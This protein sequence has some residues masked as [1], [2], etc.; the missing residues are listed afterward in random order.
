MSISR[1]AVRH[2]IVMVVPATRNPN[3]R[4]LVQYMILIYSDPAEMQQQ[5]E[6]E[7]RQMVGE[8][9]AYSESL[10]QAGVYQSGE[11][12]EPPSTATTVRVRDGKQLI[13][14]GPFAETREV[15]GGFY[16]IECESLDDALTHA[17]ACPGARHGSVEVR[18]VMQIPART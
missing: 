3:E 18:P 9:M 4:T 6:S 10:R 5:P 11:G 8:Y 15:L 1:F 14:D 7:Q 2:R 17:A 12:L 13:S 16:L